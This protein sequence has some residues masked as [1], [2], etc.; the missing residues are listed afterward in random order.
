MVGEN[1][2]K[3]QASFS[4]QSLQIQDLQHELILL[5]RDVRNMR[6]VL[7]DKQI[8]S[9]EREARAANLL[10]LEPSL[11]KF[12]PYSEDEIIPWDFIQRS[13]YSA[14]NL[15]PRRRIESAYREGID[16]VI[17]EVSFIITQVSKVYLFPSL[18]LW[19]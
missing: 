4:F 13:M 17:R 10:G 6:Q 12:R 18:R 7:T 3:M 16:D 1:N 14:G 15:N 19:K 2:K 5:Q 11:T 9:N 8:L